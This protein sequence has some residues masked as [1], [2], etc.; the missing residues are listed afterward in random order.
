MIT[1][2]QM[3]PSSLR[4]ALPEA[5]APA[6]SSL[7]MGLECLVHQRYDAAVEAF[8][9]SMATNPQDA[10][11]PYYLALARIQ[12]RRPRSLR[13]DIVKQVEADLWKVGHL[14]RG[15]E[16]AHFWF[17]QALI[18]HDFYRMNGLRIKPPTVEELLADAEIAP[19][20][21]TELQRLLDHVPTPS[22][23]VRQAIEKRL[24]DS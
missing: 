19:A 11:A 14:L 8:N 5:V 15:Q 17:F 4:T 12:G 24:I 10:A 6:E 21:A 20:D 13:A 22:N 1:A 3:A 18:K 16:P 7:E 23:P 9:Q 2:S